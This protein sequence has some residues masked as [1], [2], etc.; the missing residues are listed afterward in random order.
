M[1]KYCNHYKLR[2]SVSLKTIMCFPFLL[3]LNLFLKTFQV[4]FN[5]MLRHESVGSLVYKTSNQINDTW[6][7]GHRFNI[8]RF[9]AREEIYQCRYKNL[10][11]GS[12]A[13]CYRGSSALKGC[14]SIIL[15]SYKILFVESDK[16]SGT[17]CALNLETNKKTVWQNSDLKRQAS[18]FLWLRE[19]TQG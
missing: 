14:S 9:A 10:R 15:P 5:Q 6:L 3:I 11:L 1:N 12:V 19:K 4:F 18:F 8:L 17:L 2:N 16:T 13:P 7:D